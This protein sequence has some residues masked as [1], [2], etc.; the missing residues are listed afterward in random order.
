MNEVIT[1]EPKVVFSLSGWCWRLLGIQQK[2][3]CYSTRVY[4]WH[5][6]VHLSWVRLLTHQTLNSCIAWREQ[7]KKIEH[8]WWNVHEWGLVRWWLTPGYKQSSAARSTALD[9]GKRLVQS[10]TRELIRVSNMF[11]FVFCCIHIIARYKLIMQFD[12][13]VNTTKSVDET[14]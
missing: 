14:I 13:S 2:P 4:T 1:K 3:R 9:Q 10:R 7:I 5:T 12:Q 6:N 8:W 11:C